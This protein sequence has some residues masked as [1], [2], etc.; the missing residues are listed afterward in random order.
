[1]GGSLACAMTST[2]S[3]I[4]YAKGFLLTPRMPPKYSSTSSPVLEWYN[5]LS[6]YSKMDHSAATDA[7]KSVQKYLDESTT[8]MRNAMRNKHR[9]IQKDQQK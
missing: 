6:S 7:M 4:T 9:K 3:L 1:M 2:S 8:L 5:V